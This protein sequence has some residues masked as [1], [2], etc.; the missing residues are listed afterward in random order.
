MAKTLTDEEKKQ[1]LL[2]T[3]LKGMQEIESSRQQL[4][5]LRKAEEEAKKA[6]ELAAKNREEAEKNAVEAVKNIDLIRKFAGI[7]PDTPEEKN[8]SVYGI[9]NDFIKKFDAPETTD[10]SEKVSYIG[11]Y[12]WLRKV[13]SNELKVN[14]ERTA[15]YFDIKNI[16]YAVF[17]KY[18]DIKKTEKETESLL[19]E[20]M[21]AFKKEQAEK[22]AEAKA[23]AKAK[24]E[25]KKN[26]NNTVPN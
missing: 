17:K 6:A 16:R 21:V 14:N 24:R 20:K 26:N 19:G 9:L 3:T 7:Q 8:K 2:E 22:K 18:E 1:Q 23:R 12:E 10:F 15:Y 13:I 4:E 11:D 5:K 25:Q